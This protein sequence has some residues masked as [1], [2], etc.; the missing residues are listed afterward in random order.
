MNTAI[1]KA[2]RSDLFWRVH[3]YPCFFRQYYCLPTLV[4]CILVL[5]CLRS[6]E[7]FHLVFDEVWH[8]T[9]WRLLWIDRQLLGDDH[10]YGT[11]SDLH[12]RISRCGRPHLHCSWNICGEVQLFHFRRSIRGLSHNHGIVLGELP[13]NPDHF[14]IFLELWHFIMMVSLEIRSLMNQDS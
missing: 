12:D 9:I 6:A 10:C 1:V 7:R 2:T 3:S 4:C 13:N 11:T 8:R 5:S 14:F